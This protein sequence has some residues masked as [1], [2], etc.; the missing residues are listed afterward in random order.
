M[1]CSE[2]LDMTGVSDLASARGHKGTKTNQVSCFIY[3]TDK[4]VR[5][6]HLSMRRAQLLGYW[7]RLACSGWP[8]GLIST[9]LYLSKVLDIN[10]PLHFL[11][12]WP[13]HICV[14]CICGASPKGPVER[15]ENINRVALATTFLCLLVVR[16]NATSLPKPINIWIDILR[17]PRYR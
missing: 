6:H 1:H 2:G 13:S 5:Q 4:P 12:Y 8:A 14:Y 15:Q 9:C 10:K 11:T 3:I 17:R 16:I 7:L